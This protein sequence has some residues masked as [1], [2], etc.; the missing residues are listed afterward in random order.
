MTAERAESAHSESVLAAP[1]VIHRRPR[2]CRLGAIILVVAAAIGAVACGDGGESSEVNPATKAI[3]EK[4]PTRDGVDTTEVDV[5][6]GPEGPELQAI[7]DGLGHLIGETARE[8]KAN[9][10][11]PRYFQ[12]VEQLYGP[13]PVDVILKNAVNSQ[14]Y[15]F[16]RLRENPGDVEFRNPRV[17]NSTPTCV[18]MSVVID[19]SAARPRKPGRTDAQFR[20]GN[21][22]RQYLVIHADA[23]NEVGWRIVHL[24]VAKEMACAT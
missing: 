4:D 14:L 8:Q 23:I 21:S 22:A 1:S 17:V 12:L 20:A 18:A 16:R 15:N 24:D 5:T 10:L 2:A 9:G 11:T 19:S 7:L 3:L 6:T 13:E